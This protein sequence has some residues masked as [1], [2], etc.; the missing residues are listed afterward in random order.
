[1]STKYKICAVQ[2]NV[3]VIGLANWVTRYVGY[4]TRDEN[5]FL[6]ETK[7]FFGNPK[8]SE[9]FAK[10]KCPQPSKLRVQMLGWAGSYEDANEKVNKFIN[11]HQTIKNGWNTLLR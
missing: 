1:M 8:I 7:L 3:N 10:T 5:T 2:E 4:T 11:M 6:N 9:K